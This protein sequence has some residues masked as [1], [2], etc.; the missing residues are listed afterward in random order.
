V[1]TA[2]ARPSP[3]SRKTAAG[4]S[5]FCAT[6]RRASPSISPVWRSSIPK[7]RQQGMARNRSRRPDPA[8]SRGLLD[9][10]AHGEANELCRPLRLR[11]RDIV[12]RG[13]GVI[14]KTDGRIFWHRLEPSLGDNFQMV[15]D[16]GNALYFMSATSGPAS[17]GILAR[18][19][20]CTM[21]C[22]TTIKRPCSV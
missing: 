15:S 11:H 13:A 12:Q 16:T 2:F 8:R 21:A 20:S 6:A 10:P 7:P 18:I 17:A 5:S 1:A 4:C 22:L 3:R 9:P 14:R 19:S